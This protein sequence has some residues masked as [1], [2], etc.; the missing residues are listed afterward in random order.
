MQIFHIFVVHA[1][2]QTKLDPKLCKS[3]TWFSKRK[4]KMWGFQKYFFICSRHDAFQMSQI[5][6][7]R[8]TSRLN[9][10]ANVNSAAIPIGAYQYKSSGISTGSSST[11]TLTSLYCK[12]HAA[13]LQLEAPLLRTERA[14]AAPRWRTENWNEGPHIFWDLVFLKK[15][16]KNVACGVKW[17]YAHLLD[18]NIIQN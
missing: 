11:K 10:N 8:R 9:S 13:N 6:G 12:D 4:K 3:C 7:A 15:K 17:P 16:R 2:S 14:L 5:N 18:Q 1:F